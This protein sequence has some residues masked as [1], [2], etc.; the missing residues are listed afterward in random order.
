MNHLTNR[1]YATF[2]LDNRIAEIERHLRIYKAL[3]F[4][5][6]KKETVDNGQQIIEFDQNLNIH[7]VDE[8]LD[9]FMV[10]L[11]VSWSEGKRNL[12][13]MRSTIISDF[14]QSAP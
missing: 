1:I 11:T 3:P 5:V 14:E 13:L 4:E 2:L 6:E 8:F 10:Q 12:S 7:Q 9:I